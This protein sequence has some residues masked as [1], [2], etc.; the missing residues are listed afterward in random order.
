MR[1]EG[2]GLRDKGRGTREGILEVTREGSREG[3]GEG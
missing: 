3:Q 1:D 2:Q